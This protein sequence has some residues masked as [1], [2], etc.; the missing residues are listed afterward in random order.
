MRL[1]TFSPVQFRNLKM[2]WMEKIFKKREKKS[3]SPSSA[4]K[5]ED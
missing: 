2:G 5:E 4:K 3:D 1:R